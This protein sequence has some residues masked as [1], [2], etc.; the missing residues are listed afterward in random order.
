MFVNE[1]KQ[2]CLNAL[3]TWDPTIFDD[4]VFPDELDESDQAIIIDR[5][6]SKYGNTP[7]EHPDPAILKYGIANWSIRRS[8][9]WGRFLA[10]AKAEYDPLSNYDR[11]EEGSS[12]A[13]NTISADNASEYQ[14]D[15]KTVVT[16]DLH[17][18]GNIGVTTSQQMLEAE[19]NIIGRLDPAEYIADDFRQEFCLD[20]Y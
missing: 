20:I 13:E 12:S 10:A 5:I 2:G 19:L 18:Y 3:L 15:S 11:H 7:L 9:I 6:I 17:T 16:P 8:F 4:M 14:P 1:M